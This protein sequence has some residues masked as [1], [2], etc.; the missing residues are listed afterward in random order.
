MMITLR[1]FL[2]AV[3]I[4]RHF[5]LSLYIYDY[6]YNLALR[7]SH[8]LNFALQQSEHLSS[9]AYSRSEQVQDNSVNRLSPAAHVTHWELTKSIK[10][11]LALVS[12]YQQI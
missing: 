12:R 1:M 6:L 9:S 4:I 11:E 7:Q 5:R 8:Q 3:T 10:V 2:C